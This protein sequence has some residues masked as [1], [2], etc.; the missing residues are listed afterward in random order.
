MV[1]VEE[2][3]AKILEELDLSKEVADEEL[4]EIIRC[5]LEEKGRALFRYFLQILAL[6]SRNPFHLCIFSTLSISLAKYPRLSSNAYKRLFK[7][8]GVYS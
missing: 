1:K 3:H 6:S 7:S 8:A 5:I 4:K 2:L